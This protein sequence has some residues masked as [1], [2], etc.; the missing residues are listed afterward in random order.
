M[1]YCLSFLKF[2]HIY[3]EQQNL[4]YLTISYQTPPTY[5]HTIYLP[6]FLRFAVQETKIPGENHR[7]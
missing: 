6:T 4:L 2:E 7:P 5:L 1:A 3:H